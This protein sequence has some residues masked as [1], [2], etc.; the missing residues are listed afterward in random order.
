MD[1]GDVNVRYNIIAYGI[2]FDDNIKSFLSFTKIILWYFLL[3]I[4]MVSY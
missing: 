1:L 4:G 3:L 2:D